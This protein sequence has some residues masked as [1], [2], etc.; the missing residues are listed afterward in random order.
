MLLYITPR[1]EL[2][3]WL[4]NVRGVEATNKMEDWMT[5]HDSWDELVGEFD[6]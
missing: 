4:C 1:V 5:V 6:D 3:V 2:K